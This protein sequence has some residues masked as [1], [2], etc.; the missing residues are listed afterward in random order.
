[1]EFI[2][3][4]RETELFSN[5]LYAYT[6]AAIVFLVSLS[7]LKIFKSLIVSKILKIAIK[8]E[9]TLD[10]MLIDAI[11]II[12][13]PF[14]VLV[15]L[16]VSF[17]FISLPDFL[18]GTIY[19]LVLIS[20]IY[21]AIKFAEK[22]IDH[23]SK[24]IVESKEEEGGAEIVNLLSSVLKIVLWVGAVVLLLSNMGYNVTSLIAGLGIGGIAV[25]LALQNILSDL[26]SS[27]SIYFDKPF[28][29]GDFVT[30]NGYSGNIKKIGIKTTRIQ[31]LQGEEIVMSNNE[32]T[33]A[34]VQNFGLMDRRRV[35]LPLGVTYQTS[36][37]KLK[38][39]PS[40]IKEIIDKQE[41]ATFDRS[42]FK[43]Y[44]DSSLGFETVYY[45]ESA[46]YAE[47]MD[48][49]EGVNLEIFRKFEEEKIE[50]AYP[51]QTLFIEK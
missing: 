12:H 8:T 19:Y 29:V 50:F 36:T 51:T 27:V 6:L 44:G 32:L 45:I 43:E 38:K 15:S 39:I 1:M 14:Y 42:H 49:Q 48:I 4:L 30:I 26:F 7:V 33:Q 34:K 13:W 20:V 22:I 47:Y 16:Y 21:Y 28:K 37:E 10:D 23:F 31:A 35:V 17:R 46:E 18:S 3:S 9:N 40:I 25:A 5:S 41:G 2:L 24:K 11:N